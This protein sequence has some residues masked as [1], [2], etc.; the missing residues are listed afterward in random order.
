MYV[1]GLIDDEESQIRAIRR[2]IKTNALPETPFEFKSY[3]VPGNADDLVDKMSDEVM[4]D[5]I[6][7]KISSLVVDC[8]IIVE[9]S[10]VQ[11]TD[12]F[13]KIKNEVPKFPVIILTEVVAESTQPVFMDAD[14]V[15]RK[16]DFFK[17]EGEYSKEKVSNIFDSMKK[18]V[19]QRDK[20]ELS[21]HDLKQKL[22]KGDVGREAVSRILSLES[23]LDEFV[24]TDQTQIDKVF[25]EDKAKKI[26]D[27]IE[28]A[29]KLLG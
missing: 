4:D 3:L 12:I 13:Y 16:R 22:V 18:Y 6:E 1:I 11:G 23:Q 2:T 19:E 26:V 7:Q 17:I 8:K 15:Y 21:I 25:N 27:L 5:I 14:K 10:K 20:I 9:K 28:R 29:N 24:P